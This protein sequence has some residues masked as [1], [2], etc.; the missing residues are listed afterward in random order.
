MRTLIVRM[1]V[2]AAIILV[3]AEGEAALVRLTIE[4]REPFAGA[5]EWGSAGAYERLTGTAY[6]DVDPADPLNA[7]IVDLENAPRNARGRV[8]FSTPFFILKP[9]DVGILRVVLWAAE[10][11]A[12]MPEDV[13]HAEDALDN[14]EAA[15]AVVHRECFVAVMHPNYVL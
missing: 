2:A 1:V 15:L 4:H 6:F 10:H 14:E 5:V 3:S 11:G 12:G 13:T 7:V 8:E 9:V